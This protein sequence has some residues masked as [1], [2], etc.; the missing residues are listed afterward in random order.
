MEEKKCLTILFHSV[1]PYIN[2]IDI[3]KIFCNL[4]KHIIVSEPVANSIYY[5][6]HFKFWKC[7]L[8]LKVCFIEKQIVL[9][10]HF[11]RFNATVAVAGLFWD[12]SQLHEEDQALR[13]SRGQARSWKE[14]YFWDFAVIFILFIWNVFKE[15]VFFCLQISFYN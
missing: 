5:N 7:S 9:N 2:V 8:R 3:I 14:Y 15:I 11:H 13:V 10:M 4:I 6:N 1:G 12:T